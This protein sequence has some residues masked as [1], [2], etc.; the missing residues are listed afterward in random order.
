MFQNNSLSHEMEGI[1]GWP[2][3][4]NLVFFGQSTIQLTTEFPPYHDLVVLTTREK[5]ILLIVLRY[6]SVIK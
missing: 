6:I 3:L 5:G 1:H 2:F 4:G